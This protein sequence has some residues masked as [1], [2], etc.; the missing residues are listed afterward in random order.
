ME[1]A[2]SNLSLNGIEGLS[3]FSCPMQSN[4]ESKVLKIF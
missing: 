2:G 1:E 3:M 4:H